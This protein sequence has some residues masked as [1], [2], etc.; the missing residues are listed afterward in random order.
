MYIYHRKV[1]DCLVA[2]PAQTLTMYFHTTHTHTHTH[3]HTHTN[4]HTHTHT[5]RRR[6]RKAE[7]I[8]GLLVVIDKYSVCPF[9]SIKFQNEEMDLPSL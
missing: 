7:V 3:I 8:Q 2:T 1:V 6:M 9:R 4:T 5:T